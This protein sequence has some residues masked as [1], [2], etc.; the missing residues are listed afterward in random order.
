MK[1]VSRLLVAGIALALAGTAVA[2]ASAQTMPDSR[3]IWTVVN[4]NKLG[5]VTGIQPSERLPG[6]EHQL[7]MKQLHAWFN[8]PA[9]NKDGKPIS[10]RFVLKL[11]MSTT[12]TANGN[13]AAKFQIAKAMPVNF[14][15]S[16]Y[17]NM[18]EPGDYLTLVSSSAHIVYSNQGDISVANSPYT[19]PPPPMP[20]NQNGSTPPPPPPPPTSSGH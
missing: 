5:K 8:K 2:G 10:S 11:A 20:K 14:G 7:L 13:Y 6:W 17:W 18:S 19:P 12:P 4:V 3:I 1:T 16:V 9:T 15:G